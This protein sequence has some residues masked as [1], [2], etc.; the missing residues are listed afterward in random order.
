[1]NKD[2]KQIF[3]SFAFFA[4]ACGM[5]YNFQEL[6]MASNNLSVKTIGTVYSLCALLSV[7]IIFLCSNLLKQDKIKKFTCLSLGTF[8]CAIS[9]KLG[10]RYNFLVATIFIILATMF[11]FIAIR[12]HNIERNVKNDR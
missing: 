7:S 2:I 3:I 8:I 11:G 9:L 4:L 1:M 10:F 5:F 6:W 12:L